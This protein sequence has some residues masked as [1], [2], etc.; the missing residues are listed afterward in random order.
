MGNPLLGSTS[1][2]NLTLRKARDLFLEDNDNIDIKDIYK[3]T[4]VHPPIDEKDVVNKE[5]CDNNL[6]SSSNKINILSKNIT[7]LRKGD[8]DKVTTKTLQLNKTAVNDELIDEIIKSANEVTNTVNFCNKVASDTI[9]KYKQLKQEFDNKFNQNITNIHLDDCSLLV[10]G[11]LKKLIKRLILFIDEALIKNKKTI[12]Q[13]IIAIL[14]ESKQV[15][16][17]EQAS[18]EM[19]YDFNQEDIMKDIDIYFTTENESIIS[20][21]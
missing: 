15:Y 10:Q 2:N 13:Y 12:V 5:Y 4:N 21:E 18:L 9:S 1:T 17:K 14:L 8:F 19:H 3:I 7:E 6:L 11:D 16:N 20:T